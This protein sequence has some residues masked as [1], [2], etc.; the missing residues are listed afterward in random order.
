MA[1]TQRS[2]KEN[3]AG[4]LPIDHVEGIDLTHDGEIVATIPNAEGKRGSLQVYANVMNFQDGLLGPDQ[5]KQAIELFGEYAEEARQATGSHPNIDRLFEVQ[6]GYKLAVAIRY[7]STPS[8]G[9]QPS[10]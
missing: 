2:F 9:Q 4:L 3:L 6:R 10:S 8:P 7:K 5:V 1:P